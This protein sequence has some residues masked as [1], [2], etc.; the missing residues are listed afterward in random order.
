LTSIEAQ[1]VLQNQ[2]CFGYLQ[3]RRHTMEAFFDNGRSR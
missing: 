1:I 2:L 3:K